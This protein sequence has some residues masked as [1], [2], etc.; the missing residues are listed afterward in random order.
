MLTFA[1]FA[2]LAR[3][4]GCE[5]RDCGNGH[6]QVRGVVTVN[7]WPA[8]KRRSIFVS[9][10]SEA[11]AAG[12]AAL[13]IEIAKLGPPMYRL[14]QRLS[15]RAARRERAR[16]LKK[17]PHCRWCGCDLDAHTATLEHVVP[18]AR[19][20]TNRRENLAIACEVCNHARGNDLGPPRE[21]RS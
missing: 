19:G 3:S 15:Q 1:R 14:E 9:G 17:D 7:W 5:P 13:A 12:D 11:V 8:S 2:Q 4:E 21:V 20:G 16:L 10:S 18:L 6:W